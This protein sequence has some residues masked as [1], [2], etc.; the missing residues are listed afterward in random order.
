MTTRQLIKHLNS[1]PESTL[2]RPAIEVLIEVYTTI[3]AQKTADLILNEMRSAA[4]P[5]PPVPIPLNPAAIANGPEARRLLG[6][7][8]PT[9]REWERRGLISSIPGFK[10]PL[11]FR[12]AD[13]HALILKR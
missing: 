10:R 6:I 3:L 12:L 2:E 9:L 4:P 11:K 1:L 8:A 7:S 5:A 13:I